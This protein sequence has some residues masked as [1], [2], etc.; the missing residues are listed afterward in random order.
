MS[1]PPPARRRPSASGGSSGGS[2]GGD[3]PQRPVRRT[4][5]SAPVRTPPRSSNG[6]KLVVSAGPMEGEEFVLLEDE[7]VVGRSKEAAICIQDSS[8]SRN[9]ILLRRVDSGWV[10]SDLGSGN[11]TL[12]NGE[13]ITEEVSLANGDIVTL[14]DTEVTFADMANSTMMVPV[15]PS[16]SRP[17]PSAGPASASSSRPERVRSARATPPKAVDPQEARKKKLI[18]GAIGGVALLA[19]LGLVALQ[20]RQGKLAAQRQNQARL[21]ADRRAQLGAIFQDA[22]NMVREGRWT[23]ARD[24]LLELQALE[25]EMG[26]LKDYL[27]R[28]EKEIPNQKHLAAATDALKEKKLGVTKAELDKVTQDTQMFEQVSVLKRN[29]RD[30]GDAQSREARKLLDQKQLDEAKRITDDVLRAFE[31]HRDAKL[32]NEEAVRLIEI[33]DRP[34]PPPPPPNPGK[35]WEQ[36]VTRFVDGDLSG[37]VALINACVAKAPRCKAI[38]KDMTEFGSLYKRLEDLDAKGLARL[39]SLDKEITEGRGPS[40]MARNAGTRAANIFYKSASSAKTSGQWARAVEYARRTLQ[41]DPG[42]VG[43]SN[44][45]NDL[46]VKAKDIYMQAYALKDANPED[47]IPKFKEVIAMTPSDDETHGKAKTWLEKISK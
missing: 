27:D 5:T 9:H 3:A 14:G 31:S 12:V 2:S 45:L 8:V 6:Y 33:R 19:V 20:V 4:G 39:L 34:P 17:R 47:A 43:A 36:G 16:P 42:H 11:G 10:V 35:P 40:T 44:L 26:G 23:E 13:Q 18:M 29:L 22:K 38:L 7:Y 24:K 21:E 28:A 1:N 25:P 15:A 46:R 41:A 37:A 32:L 30:A